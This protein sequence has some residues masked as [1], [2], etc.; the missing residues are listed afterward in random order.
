M[1]MLDRAH[2]TRWGKSVL[3]SELPGLLNRA[4]N[5]IHWESRYTFERKELGNTNSLGIKSKIPK[6]VMQSN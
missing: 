3:G 4:L 2:L 5:Y 1:L 6:M